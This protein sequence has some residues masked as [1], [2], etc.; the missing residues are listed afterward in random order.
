LNSLTTS[1]AQ[2]AATQALERT[3]GDGVNFRLILPQAFL[4]ADGLLR[5]AI[6]IARGLQVNPKVIA[7]PGRWWRD[8][9]GSS[10]A[11]G[12]VRAAPA[13]TAAARFGPTKPK[14]TSRSPSSEKPVRLEGNSLK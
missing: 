4:T 5:L 14:R 2:T 1:A 11:K 13:S 10:A 9:P 7:R 12:P 8:S 6:N 3:R